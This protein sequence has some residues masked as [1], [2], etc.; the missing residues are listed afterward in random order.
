MLTNPEESGRFFAQ[1]VRNYRARRKTFVKLARV[2]HIGHDAIVVLLSILIRY[3]TDDIGFSGDYPA[4]ASASAFLRAS[5]FFEALYE[6]FKNQDRY[7]VPGQHALSTHADRYVDSALTAS[8]IETAAEA[9]WGRRSRSQGTQRVLL[10]LMLNTNNHASPRQQGEKHWWL[11]VNQLP[12]ENRAAFAFIDH[13]VGIPHSLTHKK[14]GGR[15]ALF[16]EQFVAWLVGKS[17]L[18]IMRQ[19]LSGDFHRQVAGQEFRGKGLPGIVQA[20]Q[21]GW[22]SNLVIISND[23]YVDVG[24]N[25]FRSLRPPFEGTLVCWELRTDNRHT[26]AA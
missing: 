7:T 23:V 11:F 25:E 8:V 9:V 14:R 4:N 13:G 10:E 16:R 24:R 12:D 19:V 15:F 20:C 22:L 17:N 21:R 5:G 26:E 1:L 3:K 6:K 2:E 18:D